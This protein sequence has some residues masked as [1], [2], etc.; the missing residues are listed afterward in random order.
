[1][2]NKPIDLNKFMVV[3]KTE[4]SWDYKH[5]VWSVSLPPGTSSEVNEII[6]GV[7]PTGF[8]EEYKPAKLGR[9]TSYLALAFSAGGGA[10]TEF[11]VKQ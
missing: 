2:H 7:V 10:S 3:T 6:Y 8:S 11:T 9:L 4:G 5:P 1:M